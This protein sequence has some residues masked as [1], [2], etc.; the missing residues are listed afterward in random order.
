MGSGRVVRPRELRHA[1]TLAERRAWY[2]LRRR[3]LAGL[4]FRRQQ[5]IDH[6]T[7]DFYC[8]ELRL[9][10]ELDGGVHSQPSQ[11]KR[12]QQKDEYLRALA[13]QV[14]RIPNGLVLED[15]DGFVRKIRDLTPH[16]ALRATLSRKG[17][18]P[19]LEF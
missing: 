4:K 7:V 10:L 15:P 13:I 1:Q 3:S 12:D 11:L 19:G 5:P 9:A 6:Y 2:L 17:R 8:P 14:V 18:G 16:P